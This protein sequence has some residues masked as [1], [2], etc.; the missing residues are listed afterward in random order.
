MIFKYKTGG[1]W[2]LQDMTHYDGSTTGS[3]GGKLLK[4][5]FVA[6]TDT[7]QQTVGT[8]GVEIVSDGFY[9]TNWFDTTN[10]VIYFAWKAN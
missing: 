1:D 9:P 4:K 2:Y 8:G 3:Y 10:G 5:Y 6:N 7:A